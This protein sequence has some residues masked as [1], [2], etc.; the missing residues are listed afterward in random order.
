MRS[1]I[2]LFTCQRLFGDRDVDVND[3]AAFRMTFGGPSSIFDFDKDGDVDTSDFG[4]FRTRF[5]AVI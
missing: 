4:A 3:F 1:V 5:G 2:F